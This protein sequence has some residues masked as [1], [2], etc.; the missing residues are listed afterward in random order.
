MSTY[1]SALIDSHTIL[2]D[3]SLPWIA[4][5]ALMELNRP[6]S[7]TANPFHHIIDD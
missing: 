2:V 3:P 5:K 6:T 7:S 4:G 1:S